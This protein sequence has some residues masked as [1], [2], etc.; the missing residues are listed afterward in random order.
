MLHFNA[1]CMLSKCRAQDEHIS[2]WADSRLEEW[3]RCI[4]DDAKRQRRR[5]HSCRVHSSRAMQYFACQRPPCLMQQQPSRQRQ[6][7]APYAS[8]S[9]CGAPTPSASAR[10]ASTT[11][12]IERQIEQCACAY[13]Q[14]SRLL[15]QRFTL[16]P[17]SFFHS[18]SLSLSLSDITYVS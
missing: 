9:S 6:P 14:A 11:S 7:L 8:V 13:E 4:R 16:L 18:L 10:S 17:L 15:S 12:R 3:T 2:F 1:P 5:R